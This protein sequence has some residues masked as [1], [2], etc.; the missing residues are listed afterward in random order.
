MI[1]HS[2]RFASALP[3]LFL[4]TLCAPASN[5]AEMTISAEEYSDA[6]ISTAGELVGA[7]NV[8]ATETVNT[9][10]FTGITT[11]YTNPI[12]LSGGVEL[13]AFN[14]V[15]DGSQAN[16]APGAL[17]NVHFFT[18]GP[19]TG[20]LTFT[21]LANLQYYEL[22]LVMSD[23]RA[24]NLDI[25]GD[26]TTNTG[27]SDIFVDHGNSASKIVT[28]TFTADATGTR[29]LYIEVIPGYPGHFNALQLRAV[30]PPLFL[31]DLE[32]GAPG[33]TTV[34]ND[35]GGNTEWQLGAPVGSTGPLAGAEDSAAAWCTNLGDYGIDSDISLRSPAIDLTEVPGAILSFEAFR[36]ADG[37]ADTAEVRFLRAA[38]QVPLGAPVALDMTAFGIDFETIEI[39]VDNAAI[40]ETVIIEFNFVSNGSADA[41]S[42]LTLDNISVEA[43]EANLPPPPPMG[44]SS[45]DYADAAISTAG[46]L[47][48]ALNV[49]ATETVNTVPFTGI[50]T[51]YTNPIA[52]AG[53]VTLDA[54]NGV[55]D[56]SQA[57]GAPGALTNVHFFTAGPGTG[58]LTFTGLANLQYYELQ[59]VMSDTRAFNLDIWGDQTTNTG[60]SDIFVDH[61]NS[62][63]KIVT[64]TFTAD[65]TGTRSL[66]IEVIPGYPGHFNALQLRAIP[67]DG[68]FEISSITKA[69]A[70]TTIV[71]EST[72]GATYIIEFSF[73]LINWLEITDSFV[74]TE[75]TTT[76]IDDDVDIQAE[77][78]VFYR[79]T[80]R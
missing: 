26:Q 74:A 68:P 14:G 31:D 56:G 71:F 23:T 41:F 53:G 75:L 52:F 34:V 62:A 55:G 33:W 7:L 40:G 66:Y 32:S 72:I 6:A 2:Q 42:G 9:V 78:R 8:G 39:P 47:V 69:G 16:G 28:V 38:D 3:A 59:L 65:A 12:A 46:E 35:G 73:D 64:V 63:S 13:D 27:A 61:G 43:S 76:F 21:G 58:Y 60:A 4:L 49:G 70:E 19:G 54:F 79:V 30:P 67:P 44:F 37:F 25:W 45:E 10:P 17:T 11:G 24:F 57:N 51:G 22:Q 20:Y 18:A 50:T 15:G 77:A 1:P 80:R 36:D 5:A 48:G 29:S